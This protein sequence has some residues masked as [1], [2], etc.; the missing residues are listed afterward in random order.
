MSR[1]TAQYAWDNSGMKNYM[2]TIVI[3]ALRKS[4]QKHN[5]YVT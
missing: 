4:G 3:R 2:G 1:P 5:A